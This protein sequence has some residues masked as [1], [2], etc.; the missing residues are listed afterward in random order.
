MSSLSFCVSLRSIRVCSGRECCHEPGVI[1]HLL[2]IIMAAQ[3]V[4]CIVFSRWKG[5]FTSHPKYHSEVPL[6]SSGAFPSN[7]PC[8]HVLVQF[9]WHVHVH[10][11]VSH[12]S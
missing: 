7:L 5:F 4:C 1:V 6:P 11:R 9:C 2:H 12:V 10:F 3:L 8:E